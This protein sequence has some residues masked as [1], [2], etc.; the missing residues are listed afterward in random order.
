MRRLLAEREA[1]I[2]RVN[3][4]KKASLAYLMQMPT[5]N[6]THTS[7]IPPVE[8]R[9]LQVWEDA[10]RIMEEKAANFRTATEATEQFE[11]VRT[12]LFN[13]LGDAQFLLKSSIG[14]VHDSK[15][16]EGAPVSSYEAFATLSNTDVEKR[17]SIENIATYGP[18][19]IHEQTTAIQAHLK[20]LEKGAADITKLRRAA[21]LIAEQVSPEKSAELE[22]IIDQLERDMALTKS[23]LEERLAALEM[24]KSRWAN[25][26]EHAQQLEGSLESQESTLA[27]LRSHIESASLESCDDVSSACDAYR[28]YLETYAHYLQKLQSDAA[29]LGA[30]IG[31][32]DSTLAAM[33]TIERVDENGN[34]VTET[35]ENVDPEVTAAQ[36]N[37][38][39]LLLRQKGVNK[40]CLSLEQIITSTLVALEEYS[41]LSGSV[42]TYLNRVEAAR[43]MKHAFSD[44]KEVMAVKERLNALL[45]MRQAEIDSATW[46]MRE[47]S[48][49]LKKVPQA[50][51]S[52]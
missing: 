42:E 14:S 2:A 24:A 13:L 44:L 21:D 34:I 18:S 28:K 31:N 49:F 43:G 6:T 36:K 27:D 22:S 10:D 41:K 40:A 50:A 9:F 48:P 38:H 45:T 37:L 46:R 3:E 1:L 52:A 29:N 33:L 11:E 7:Q 35:L 19:K 32:V 16:T 15:P 30:E 5:L 4:E 47:L 17:G 12:R 20:L 51:V 8:G 23:A 39:A 25:I 26:H